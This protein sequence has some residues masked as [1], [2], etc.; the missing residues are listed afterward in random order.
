MTMS[1]KMDTASDKGKVRKLL[2]LQTRCRSC[3][4]MARLCVLA[5]EEKKED[6]KD[7]ALSLDD[8]SADSEVLKLVSQVRAAPSQRFL[9]VS[10]SLSSLTFAHRLQENEKI[11]VPKKVA[12]MSELV[13]TMAEGGATI[14]S[15]LVLAPRFFGSDDL[16]TCRQGGE[17]NPAAERQVRGV[18]QGGA[19][20]EVPRR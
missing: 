1:G 3:V 14:S 2:L 5:Q 20:H 16:L 19:V 15:L 10:V 12:I 18:E 7:E 6:K 8:S 17:G 9:R 13:K 4:L 11:S